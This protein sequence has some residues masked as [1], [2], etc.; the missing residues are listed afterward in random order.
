M[1]PRVGFILVLNV[2]ILGGKTK[3]SLNIINIIL[4]HTLNLMETII[5]IKKAENQLY[6][7]CA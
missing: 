2:V 7:L 1:S 4:I 3:K 6:V 5:C